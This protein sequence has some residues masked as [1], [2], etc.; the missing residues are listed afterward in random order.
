MSFASSTYAPPKLIEESR[1]NAYQGVNIVQ[2]EPDQRVLAP[3]QNNA[4]V[5]SVE[6]LFFT[7]AGWTYICSHDFGQITAKSDVET[8]LLKLTQTLINKGITTSAELMRYL[9]ANFNSVVQ[10]VAEGKYNSAIKT[11]MF[12]TGV[13]VG[14]TA[15]YYF[16]TSTVKKVGFLS[17][18]MGSILYV[19]SPFI[20][21]TAARVG[22][23][24]SAAAATTA[25]ATGGVA[26]VIGGTAVVIGATAYGDR[27]SDIRA[28]K[29][30]IRAGKAEAENVKLRA[31]LAALT[32]KE[33]PEDA[34]QAR[35][36]AL[37]TAAATHI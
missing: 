23:V 6:W 15:C 33:D 3:I 2:M 10:V 9:Q 1:Q 36:N 25:V 5:R 7:M 13:S 30:D 16:D 8:L 4:N 11:L 27:Q 19:V 21:N 35:R 22:I 24:A 29:A 18:A 26:L 14:Y 20:G 34:N 31:M 28:D 37:A 32:P 12:V 17:A